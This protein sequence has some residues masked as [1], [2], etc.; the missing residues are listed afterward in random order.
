MSKLRHKIEIKNVGGKSKYRA[1]LL[2]GEF[3]PWAMSKA[4]A[5]RHFKYMKKIKAVLV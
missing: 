4:D 5:W 2:N 3:G 1:V